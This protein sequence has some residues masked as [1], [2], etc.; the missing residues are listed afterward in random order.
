MKPP[1][2]RVSLQLNL[3]LLNLPACVVPNDKQAELVLALVELLVGAAHTTVK[4]M[5]DGGGDERE[6]Y[7]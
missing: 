6:T 1:P 7:R 2:S 5:R 4:N 3:P